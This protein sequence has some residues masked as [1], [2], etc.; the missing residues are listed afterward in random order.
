MRKQILQL[1]KTLDRNAQKNVF[2]GALLTQ[3]NAACYDAQEGNIPYGCPCTSNSQCPAGVEHKVTDGLINGL[4]EQD[5]APQYAYTQ[6]ICNGVC[7]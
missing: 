3:F 7:M 2:G 4:G 6:G 5:A 1:G